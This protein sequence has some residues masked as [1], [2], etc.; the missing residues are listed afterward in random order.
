MGRAHDRPRRWAVPGTGPPVLEAH[1]SPGG[2]GPREPGQLTLSSPGGIPPPSDRR[3]PSPA[4][5]SKDVRRQRV[6]RH[7]HAYPRMTRS[8]RLAG[9][10]PTQ[11]DLALSR[12]LDSTWAT[13]GNA[14]PR[15]ELVAGFLLVD[16]AVEG[17]E[18]G[19]ADARLERRGLRCTHLAA[20]ASRAASRGSPPVHRMGSPPRTSRTR[21]F[22][23]DSPATEGVGGPRARSR[24]AR[25]GGSCRPFQAVFRPG[26][27]PARSG[28][29]AA[30][31]SPGA[32]TTSESPTACG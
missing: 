28:S 26:N 3:R 31:R 23:G 22:T 1:S 14:L 18:P 10:V 5:R 11:Q 16:A 19:S 30:T 9:D 15:S 6:G 24:K 12:R 7:G 2:G 25:G 17:G 32:D 20:P 29:P 4:R 8:A 13:A 27:S 21:G